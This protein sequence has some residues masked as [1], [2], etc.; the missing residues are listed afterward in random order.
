MDVQN[1]NEIIIYFSSTLS[2]IHI[3]KNYRVELVLPL[4]V[5][6]NEHHVVQSFLELERIFL[7][8][9]YVAQGLVQPG[10]HRGQSI[11]STDP[12]QESV[13]RGCRVQSVAPWN[14]IY[15]NI[16]PPIFFFQSYVIIKH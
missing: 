4:Y 3:L 2:S 14:H 16:T 5:V 9:R 15:I 11:V 13:M 7:P 12:P 6:L 1:S 10:H 8:G